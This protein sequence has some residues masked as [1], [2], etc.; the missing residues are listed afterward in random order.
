MRAD[1]NKQLCERERRGSGRKYKE[2][3]RAK[4]FNQVGEEGEGMPSFE[5][6]MHRYGYERKDFNEN[7][8]PLYSQ[9]RKAVGRPWDKFYSELC[10]NFDKRSVINNHILEHLY[11]RIEVKTVMKGDVVWV[12]PRYGDP[13]PLKESRSEYYVDP[14]D[15]IIKKNKHYVSYRQEQ[16]LRAAEKAAEEAKVTKW[17]DDDHVLRKIDDIWFI[18]TMKDLPPA[19]LVFK[20]PA[21]VDEFKVGYPG[22]S[23]TWD[24]LD[25]HDR[26]R[27]GVKELIGTSVLDVFS[28]QHVSRAYTRAER[29]HA[30]KRTASRDMLKKAGIV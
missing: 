26:K 16:R 10:E 2:F 14:R 29:Y 11:D 24:Q 18:F 23:R 8:N 19:T 27:F 1:L 12:H 17:I 25:E 5:S 13:R 28:G 7:L 22:K 3:R 4:K 21:G 15:G 20:K 9:L 30:I 6:T